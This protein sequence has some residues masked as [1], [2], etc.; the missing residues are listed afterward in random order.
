MIVLGVATGFIRV[1]PEL[2]LGT[3]RAQNP[4]HVLAVYK[5]LL[6]GSNRISHALDEG[7]PVC[8]V[9]TPAGRLGFANPVVAAINITVI[10]I[11]SIVSLFIDFSY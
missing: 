8:A 10:P 7:P 5:M 2:W 6:T 1:I 3:F 4:P 9:Q 11:F